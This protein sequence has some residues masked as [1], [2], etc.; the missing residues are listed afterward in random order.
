MIPFIC[1][2]KKKRYIWTYLQNRN[3]IS[4]VKNKH[5]YQGVRGRG[6]N[7]ETGV[8]IYTLLYIKQITNKDSTIV[9]HRELY[10]VLCSG[11]NR[12]I[13]LERV[14]ICITDSHDCTPET[15]NN[16]I[17]Y[18]Y[19]TRIYF[20]NKQNKKKKLK[21]KHLDIGICMLSH[22][23]RVQLFATLWT[24]AHQAPLSMGFSRQ[25]YCKSGLSCPPPGDLPGPGIESTSLLSPAPAGGFFT[26]S[27]T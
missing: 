8:D 12:K 14:D 17:L 27:T 1:S 24:V 10:S 9:Q 4:D 21:L 26:T 18:I 11:L 6:I 2:L 13:I 20:F 15:I 5:D 23:S 7:W 22:F 19:Y 3:R 25:E 16:T